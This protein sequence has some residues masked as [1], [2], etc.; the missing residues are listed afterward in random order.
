MR[1]REGTEGL[2]SMQ[3]RGIKGRGLSC[4][5]LVPVESLSFLS[6]P[7]LPLCHLFLLSDT[8][9]VYVATTLSVKLLGL[10]PVGGATSPLLFTWQELGYTAAAATS[11]TPLP[12]PPQ[13]VEG[14]SVIRTSSA[15]VADDRHISVTSGRL[16][17]VQPP[18]PEGTLTTSPPSSMSPEASSALSAAEWPLR[19]VAPG[20]GMQAGHRV[21][22]AMPYD[23][24]SLGRGSVEEAFDMLQLQAARRG[25]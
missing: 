12:F 25:C 9:D 11:S 6:H 2:R 23:M 10:N 8:Y 1:E 7:A 16:S 19:V 13:L 14:D 15:E 18:E 22:C 3:G 24:L 20:G 5:Y 17:R 21:A 4:D